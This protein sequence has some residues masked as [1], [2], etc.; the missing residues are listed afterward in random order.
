MCSFTNS[1]LHQ[2]HCTAVKKIVL[3]G[4]EGSENEEYIHIHVYKLF[5]PIARKG[6][7]GYY[8]CCQLK[9]LVV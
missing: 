9:L 7:I 6:M 4:I 3:C 8:L 5:V 2:C 1:S